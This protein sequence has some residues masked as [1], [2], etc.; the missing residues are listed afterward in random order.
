MAPAEA[1]KIEVVEAEG[2]RSRQGLILGG[3]IGSSTLDRIQIDEPAARF[4]EVWIQGEGMEESR[5]GSLCAIALEFERPTAAPDQGGFRISVGHGL[6]CGDCV[7]EFSAIL[8]NLGASKRSATL[9]GR[10]VLES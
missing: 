5:L 6:E 4:G 7:V 9:T 10:P 8:G 2:A 1:P 3:Q